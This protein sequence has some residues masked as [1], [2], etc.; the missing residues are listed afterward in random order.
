ME[1]EGGA[2]T[3]R[4]R[5]HSVDCLRGVIALAVVI[6]HA[7]RYE[8]LPA[9]CPAW[10]RGLAAA[11]DYGH[12]AV[13]LAFVVSGFCIHRPWARRYAETG[14]GDFDLGG[15]WRRRLRRLYPP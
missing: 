6:H 7:I 2:M 12:Q 3:E 14:R 9:G 4:S 15:Y 1:V 10:L 8:R 11:L 5:L 13:P